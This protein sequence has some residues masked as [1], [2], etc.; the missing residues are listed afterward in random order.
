MLIIKLITEI[1]RIRG[2][3]VT[4]KFGRPYAEVKGDLSLVAITVPFKYPREVGPTSFHIN[5][6]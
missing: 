4:L 2:N 1:V 5:N 3:S 6:C